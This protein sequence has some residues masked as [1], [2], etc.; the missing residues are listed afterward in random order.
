MKWHVPKE[1]E[2]GDCRI[3][4]RFAWLPVFI[5]DTRKVVW[6]EWVT[7]EEKYTIVGV[8]QLCYGWRVVREVAA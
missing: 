1:P 6:L 2:L 4:R 7:V 5:P 8:T 3:R